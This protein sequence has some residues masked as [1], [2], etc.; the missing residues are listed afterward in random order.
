MKTIV[1]V[2]DDRDLLQL[3]GE[4]L[5]AHDLGLIPVNR[6]GGALGQIRES[7]PDYLMLDVMLPDGA[8][9]QVARAV[10]SDPGLYKTPILFMSA[11]GEPPEI[12]HALNQGGDAYLTKPFSL[13][14]L[15]DRL[16]TL[17][18]LSDRINT[19]D[20][21]T[22][23]MHVEAIQREIDLE[24]L[25]QTAFS[26]AYFTIGN[27]SGYRN[28]RTPAQAQEV[29]T[30]T[31]RLLQDSARESGQ[32]A[33]RI[34][35]LGNDHFL[36]LLDSSQRKSYCKQV[37]GKFNDQ[38]VQ[39]YRSIELE[40]KYTVA[41]PKDGVFEGARLMQLNALLFDSEKHSFDNAHAILKKFQKALSSQDSDKSHA[42]FRF[43]QG[44][45]W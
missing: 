9:Y 4:T 8:G 17:D 21:Q 1:A 7:R 35:H 10:R 39:F 15:F 16:R 6:I 29:I 25:R 40:Q 30:W 20:A 36:A 24:I 38:I 34:A 22:G 43:K 18:I 19:L 5:R 45:K 27:F 28:S 26:L 23:L 3:L 31:A 2:D 13:T 14:Q 12:A 37:T 33:V 32:S 11:L 44:E 41:T 42:V